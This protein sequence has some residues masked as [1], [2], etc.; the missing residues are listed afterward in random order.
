MASSLCA[1]ADAEGGETGAR[2]E[3]EHPDPAQIESFIGELAAA[4][5][6]QMAKDG[7]FERT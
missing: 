1:H 3:G 7:L 6:K 4:V 2:R 5:S